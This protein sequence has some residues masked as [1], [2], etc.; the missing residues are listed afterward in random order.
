MKNIS[1]CLLILVF[2]GSSGCRRK[3]TEVTIPG[4]ITWDKK[5]DSFIQRFKTKT[6]LNEI[7]KCSDDGT[8]ER[9]QASY[10]DG[11]KAEIGFMFWD[12]RY[13]DV[14]AYEI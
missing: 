4:K 13:E 2:L 10:T 8:L 11:S 12:E 7:G 6:I 5:T 9:Y 14:K 3:S 1:I